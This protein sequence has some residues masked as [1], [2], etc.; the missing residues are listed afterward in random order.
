[1]MHWLAVGTMTVNALNIFPAFTVFAAQERRQALKHITT[2]L[3][4]AMKSHIRKN[5]IWNENIY[6]GVLT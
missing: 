2:G 4:T 5:T 6:L 1:M 3:T